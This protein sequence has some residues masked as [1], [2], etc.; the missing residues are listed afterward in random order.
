DSGVTIGNSTISGNGDEGVDAWND[1]AVTIGNST[2]SGN[3]VHGVRAWNDSAVTLTNT[4]ISGSGNGLATLNEAT[5]TLK[6][7]IIADS[8]TQN[9]GAGSTVVDGL[10]NWVED[11]TCGITAAGD[12]ALG[13]LQMNGGKTATHSITWSGTA[14]DSGVGST[15]QSVGSVDQRGESRSASCSPGA[16]EPQIPYECEAIVVNTV[17]VAGVDAL[18]PQV[19]VTQ[20]FDADESGTLTAG[21]TLVGGW[22]MSLSCGGGAWVRSGDTG[23]GGPG[24]ISLAAKPNSSCTLTKENKG[25]E[26]ELGYSIDGAALLM[27]TGADLSIGTTNRTVAFLHSAVEVSPA[28]PTPP[29]GDPPPTEPAV[30]ATTAPAD[31]PTVP[32]ATPT[33]APATATPT[34][35]ATEPTVAG[36]EEPTPIAP[37]TGGG[38]GGGLGGASPM[39][40]VLAAFVLFLASGGVAVFGARR[41]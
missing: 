37:S 38:P 40:L 2:I 28:W 25:L 6:N 27:G 11:G 41:R 18:C 4:T 36:G 9:C 13:P 23:T 5:I 22:N 30:T 15:C 26:K 24:L 29:S 1:S 33:E 21:D 17:P 35:P 34:D 19:I 8:G 12:P 31:T 39:T 3:T 14:Y 7:V 32:A 16:F 10:G 20:S